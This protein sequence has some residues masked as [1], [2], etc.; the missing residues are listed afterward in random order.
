M[1]ATAR[2]VCGQLAQYFVNNDPPRPL[3]D[4]MVETWAETDGD[5]AAVLRTL[6]SSKQFAESLGQPQFK[7]PMRYVLSAMR[8]SLDGRV[9][10]NTRPLIGILDRLGEPLYGRQTPDG[11]PMVTSA[12]DG[13]GQITARFEV[14]R[15]IGAGA[16]MLFVPAQPEL[17]AGMMDGAARSTDTPPHIAPRTEPPVLADSTIFMACEA[18]LSASTRQA[19]ARAD[20]R[21]L[22]N[23]IWL[24]SPEFMNF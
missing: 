17:V 16:P 23:S 5:I 1:P 14:A 9:I 4:A 7:D 8:A 19:L 18:R 24:S 13:P 10:V 22:W 20:N 12:W 6:F 2:H 11:F 3:I 21:V 15:Q